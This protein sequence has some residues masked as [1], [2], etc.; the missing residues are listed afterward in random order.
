MSQILIA[1]DD[2]YFGEMCTQEC[3][4]HCLMTN[5]CNKSSGVCIGGC[6]AGWT[7]EFCGSRKFDLNW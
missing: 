6:K 1:C 7:G 4:V 2:G 5:R 3:G